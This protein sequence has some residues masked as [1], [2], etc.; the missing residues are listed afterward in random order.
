[1]DNGEIDI[2]MLKFNEQADF[3]GKALGDASA[4]I[5]AT[6]LKNN[7]NTNYME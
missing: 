6:L 4:T 7:H 2:Q 5:I 3:S 1:M